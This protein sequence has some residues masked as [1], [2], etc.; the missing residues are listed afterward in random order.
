MSAASP[1]INTSP[2]S[3]DTDMPAL[4]PA[5]SLMVP[6]FRDRLETERVPSDE[7]VSPSATVYENTRSVEP[8]PDV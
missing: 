8:V 5:V 4:L 3:P 2:R 6:P 7:E 1:S